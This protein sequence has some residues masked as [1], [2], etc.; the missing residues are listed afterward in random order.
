M[1]YSVYTP[2]RAL[3]WNLIK[4]NRWLYN[5]EGSDPITFWR[6]Q[7]VRIFNTNSHCINRFQIKRTG[8]NFK[9]RRAVHARVFFTFSLYHADHAVLSAHCNYSLGNIRLRRGSIL[10]AP[11]ITSSC[12]ARLEKK[13]K[14]TK[15][16]S[17]VFYNSCFLSLIFGPPALGV[18]QRRRVST[19]KK[20][21]IIHYIY[22]SLARSNGLLGQILY[23]SH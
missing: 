14:K 5:V 12:F 8:E 2:T 21:D 3:Q 22:N 10:I 13:K 4:S 18:L 1:C 9:K 19:W 23:F 6:H 16:S 11:A 17:W 20:L 15:F 7:F